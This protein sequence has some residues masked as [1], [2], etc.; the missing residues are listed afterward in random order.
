METSVSPWV[1]AGPQHCP[2]IAG[3]HR[4][5]A[6]PILAPFAGLA[7]GAYTRPLFSST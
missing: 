4:H 2:L 3:A 1:Q 6:E 5:A 7:A